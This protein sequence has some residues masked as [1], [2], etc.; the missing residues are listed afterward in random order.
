MNM[1]RK[2]K[3]K[4]RKFNAEFSNLLDRKK[5]NKYKEKAWP[6]LMSVGSLVRSWTLEK[7]PDIDKHRSMFIRNSRV[8]S[9]AIS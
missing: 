7:I 9:Q 5:G 4:Y 8:G 2:N 1:T 3:P 6:K